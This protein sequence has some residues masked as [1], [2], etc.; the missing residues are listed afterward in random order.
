M[1]HNP[2]LPPGDRFMQGNV[3]IEL[4]IPIVNL[5]DPNAVTRLMNMGINDYVPLSALNARVGGNYV[6]PI[7]NIEGAAGNP[8]VSNLAALGATSVVSLGTLRH[9]PNNG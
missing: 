2:A 9:L 5:N 3:G 4:A 8:N 7:V 1:E 6:F